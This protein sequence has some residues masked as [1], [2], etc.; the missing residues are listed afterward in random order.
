[1]GQAGSSGRAATWKS[2]APRQRAAS[3]LQC[4][5]SK[6][7]RSAAVLHFALTFPLFFFSAV[8][9]P[10]MLSC[11]GMA[12]LAMAGHVFMHRV[13]RGNLA[14]LSAS[15][16]SGTFSSPLLHF[17]PDL[18]IAWYPSWRDYGVHDCCT[19]RGVCLRPVLLLLSEKKLPAG[20]V[21]QLLWKQ[22]V[23]FGQRRGLVAAGRKEA[24]K[25]GE[26]FG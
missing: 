21:L 19:S 16:C 18:Q 9:A 14:D 25:V 24:P 13:S 26:T 1:V 4:V 11:V 10:N 5:V 6:G 20:P 2:R 23:P 8:Q 7:C 3:A 15:T 17:C 12:C 22:V